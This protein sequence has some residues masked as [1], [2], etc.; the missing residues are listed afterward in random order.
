MTQ[1]EDTLM[2]QSMHNPTLIT[3]RAEHKLDM[4]CCQVAECGVTVIETKIR[5]Q[6][7]VLDLRQTRVKSISFDVDITKY[8]EIYCV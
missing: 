1:N 4:L 2:D 3:G 8:M 7:S 6:D 5:F